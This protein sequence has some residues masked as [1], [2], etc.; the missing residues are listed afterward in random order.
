MFTQARDLSSAKKHPYRDS[1]TT[2]QQ[3]KSANSNSKR[4]RDIPPS[5]STPAQHQQQYSVENFKVTSQVSPSTGYHIKMIDND[6]KVFVIDLLTDKK[7]HRLCSNIIDA[8]EEHCLEAEAAGMPQIS[9]R[10][11]YTYTKVSYTKIKL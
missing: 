5:Q 7:G 10:K 11:L 6:L 1:S 4:G 8:A 2:S 3:Q 9:W